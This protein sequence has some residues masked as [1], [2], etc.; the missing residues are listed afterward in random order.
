MIQPNKHCEFC[1][2]PQHCRHPHGSSPKPDA[3]TS[4]VLDLRPRSQRLLPVA[5]R[6]PSHLP[7]GPE[8]TSCVANSSQA[9]CRYRD[10]ETRSAYTLTNVTSL[11]SSGRAL[12]MK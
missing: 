3:S 10:S 4:H 9:A 12:Y 11:P 7:A 8:L 2:L 6:F 5:A 1:A